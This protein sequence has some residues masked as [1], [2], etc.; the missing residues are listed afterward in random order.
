MTLLHKLKTHKLFDKRRNNDILPN[1]EPEFP[2]KIIALAVNGYYLAVAAAGGH[3]TLY[4]YYTKSSTP[5][6]DELAETP[7]L[8]VPINY[9]SES[10]SSQSAADSNAA[11]PVSKKDLK[12]YL[13]TKIGLR[14][15][16]GYQ[17]ELVC[18]L[19]FYQ[20]I[21]VV[22]SININPKNST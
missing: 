2:Y 20:R 7:L 1:G 3:V 6:D 15:Q 10:K 9:E 16:S 4:K 14:R 22:T 17:P 19:S 21:P 5:G 13:R 18:L 8:E 12:S 11:E